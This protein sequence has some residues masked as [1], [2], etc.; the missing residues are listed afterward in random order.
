MVHRDE[1]YGL[2]GVS[3]MITDAE[4]DI[5]ERAWPDKWPCGVSR[6]AGARGQQCHSCLAIKMLGSFGFGRDGWPA[7]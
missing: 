4:T 2:M 5:L 1:I 7:G 6:A 3:G